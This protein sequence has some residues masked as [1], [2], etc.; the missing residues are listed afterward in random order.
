MTYSPTVSCLEDANSLRPIIIPNTT[1]NVVPRIYLDPGNVNS[2]PY[3]G[4]VNDGT[5][6]TNL[7]TNSAYNHWR[8]TFTNNDNHHPNFR[9]NAHGDVTHTP[10]YSWSI[11]DDDAVSYTHLRAHET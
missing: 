2:Y 9:L 3:Q 8:G 5:I 1:H 7:T 10:G 4:E 6:I 11:N